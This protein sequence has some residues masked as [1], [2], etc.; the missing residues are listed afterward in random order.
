MVVVTVAVAGGIGSGRC[1]TAAKGNAVLRC[2]WPFRNGRSDFSQAVST[3]YFWNYGP[4]LTPLHSNTTGR[5]AAPPIMAEQQL[6]DDDL[7]ADFALFERQISKVTSKASPK[8]T[9]P[10]PKARW[11]WDGTKW[12]WVELQQ[13]PVQNAALPPTQTASQH[14]PSLLQKPL[15]PNPTSPPPPRAAPKNPP[16]RTAA[17]QVWRD[18]TLAAWPAGD[19]RIFVGDLA[20]DATEAELTAAFSKYA[21]FN[22]ARVVTDKHTGHC[23]GYGFVSFAAGEDMIAALREM[24]G[25]YVGSRPVKLR[26][27]TWQKRNLR[28]ARWKE[29]KAFRDISTKPSRR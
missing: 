27:S 7:D 4:F 13:T 8:P 28:G 12:N 23:R 18:E 11:K 19:H 25:K 24:N 20:P 5:S 14:K 3:V 16:K 29:L 2:R 26:K 10:K 1:R 22:M 9:Q 6:Q 21:S 15:Q 17:G